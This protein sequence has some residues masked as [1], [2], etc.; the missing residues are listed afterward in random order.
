MPAGYV[1]LSDLEEDVNILS[2]DEQPQWQVRFVVRT[3]GVVVCA[4]AGTAALVRGLPHPSE[5]PFDDDGRHG[6][7]APVRTSS[8]VTATASNVEVPEVVDKAMSND[9]A[10][11]LVACNSWDDDGKWD[12]T[13][14]KGASRSYPPRLCLHLIVPPQTVSLLRKSAVGRDVW[15]LC[16]PLGSV[17]S[18]HIVSSSPAD[19]FHAW[20]NHSETVGSGSGFFKYCGAACEGDDA[21]TSYA[22]VCAWEAVA[23][24]PSICVDNFISTTPANLSRDL[25]NEFARTTLD[26]WDC[27]EH[28]FC[29]SCSTGNKCVESASM[30]LPRAFVLAYFPP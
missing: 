6:G 15:S 10:Q 29:N 30:Y 9:Y 18:P 17:V 16:S 22:M 7:L 14:G 12:S 28:A 26:L 27:D 20:C 23:Q 3:F 21:S 4:L 2:I 5:S 1:N 13:C 24:L 25:P 8:A 11:N 19:D